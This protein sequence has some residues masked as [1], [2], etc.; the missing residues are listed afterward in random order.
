MH[1]PPPSTNT[2]Y[3]GSRLSAWFLTLAAV[4][5]VIPG[6]IHTFLPDGGAGTIAHLDLSHNGALVI[7]LFAWAGATQIAFGLAALIVSVRYRSLVPLMLAL[8]LLERTLHLLNAW[9]VRSRGAG[10]HP[11]EHYA[12]LVAVPLLALALIASLRERPPAPAGD[13]TSR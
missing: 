6:T 4:L 2:A 8:M 11:P 13:T 12:V 1:L 9:V 5:T 7:A 3:Q 10:H